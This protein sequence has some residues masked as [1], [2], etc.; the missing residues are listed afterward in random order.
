MNELD[1]FLQRLENSDDSPVEPPSARMP[2]QADEPSPVSN[3]WLATQQRIRQ[4]FADKLIGQG[5][6]SDQI[7]RIFLG[8]DL[9]S[10]GNASTRAVM[11]FIGPDGVGK[12]LS[13]QLLAKTL[14]D[15][16]HFLALDLGQIS[17]HNQTSIL[18]GDDP[19]FH[20]AAP[21]L[22][23]THVA[24]HPQTVVFFDN[25]ERCHP[26][27]LARLNVLLD[28]GEITD[29]FG[30]DRFG[31]PR[32]NHPQ[33][34]D[35]RKAVL[36]FSTTAGE[37]TYADTQFQAVLA[38]RP[39]HAE[40][41][42][43]ATL[44]QL[45]SVYEQNSA[46][47]QFTREMI[48][49]WR[50][51]RTVLFHPLPL[52]A[53]TQIAHKALEE[54]ADRLQ[55]RTGLTLN[56]L[57][58]TDWLAAL[59]LSHA[60]DVTSSTAADALPDQFVME[61]MQLWLECMPRPQ[62][63]TI[64]VSPTALIE[65]QTVVKRLADPARHTEL[66]TAIRR[67]GYKT[68]LTWALHKEPEGLSYRLERVVLSQ[69]QWAEDLIGTGSLRIEVPKVGFDDIAGHVVVKRRLQEVINMLRQSHDPAAQELIPRG[70]LL[71]GPP[72]TGK[73]MLAR[74]LA[75]EADLPFIN[76][77]GS[78]LLDP[79]FTRQ[80]FVRARRYAPAVVF[81]DEIDALGTREDGASTG[82][83][84][85]INQLLAELDG[86]D[87]NTQ[88]T[89]FVIAATNLAHTID[90]ALRRPG[91]LDLRMEVPVLDPLARGYFVDQIMRLPM[92]DG[93]ARCD[94]IRLTAGMSGAQLTQL[95][96]EL[97]LAQLRQEGAPLTKAVVLETFN[98]LVFG[99]R[100]TRPLSQDYLE[101]TAIHEAGHAVVQ[102]LVNPEQRITQISIIHRGYVAGFVRSDRDS[103]A[104]HRYT[105][106]E[107]LD[108]LCV[109]LAG[110]N[111]Q[112]RRALGSADDGA[113]SDLARATELALAAVGRWGLCP[114]YGL[115]ALDDVRHASLKPA[116]AHEWLSAARVL[117]RE[118]D[119]R[120]KVLI[121][122]HWPRI[123]ALQERLLREEFIMDDRL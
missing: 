47:R 108:E 20:N 90:P 5:A 79:T 59:L 99:E 13:A 66:L 31:N 78:E 73:T 55:K 95:Q 71:Y 114:S 51:G 76:T 52:D 11:L 46:R 118:A 80:L 54:R 17:H 68:D 15:E 23:T 53:L 22:M 8:S 18:V 64:D 102:A 50:G 61:L 91:R 42:L 69:L 65:W 26:A 100:S 82:R 111:A 32:Q 117:L 7:G 106:A 63:V 38:K 27:V 30:I 33:P 97:R 43:L 109:L 58:K 14:G 81:I 115:L 19:S 84:M 3:A 16:Y 93:L 92:A 107:V 12:R 112:E 85:A 39:S 44:A 6:A 67:R 28:D 94:M 74:A 101:N 25:V 116:V 37:S 98:T 103:L 41:M 96:R 9:L 45:P 75:H 62:S 21:G 70:M 120:C 110:R 77:T 88:G 35:F 24:K 72:G 105:H 56:G 60:P 86:F 113:H 49:H 48:N 119:Q 123:L 57:D 29:L 34:T 89:L 83:V 36:I 40:S 87:G 121:N 1:N 2:E 4:T 104:S 122:D 10:R